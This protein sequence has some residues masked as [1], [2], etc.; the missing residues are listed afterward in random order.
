MTSTGDYFFFN[1]GLNLAS[2]NLD[3]YKVYPHGL[4]VEP[5]IAKLTTYSTKEASDMGAIFI[6]RAGNRI[7]NESDPYT[8]F[9]DAIAAQKDQIAFALASSLLPR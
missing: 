9:R 5:G 4:E 7:V 2:R 3:W 6:N 8:H 1:K